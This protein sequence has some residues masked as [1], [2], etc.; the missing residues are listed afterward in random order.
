LALILCFTVGCQDKAAMAELEAFKAQAEVEEQNKAL[1]IRYSEAWSK[2]D[3]EALKE[4]FSPDFVWH[5][6]GAHLSL[7]ETIESLKQQIAM[8][9][10][11]TI[12]AQDIIVKE[13][14]LISRYIFRGTHEGDT[15]G[16]PA[17]GKT[18]EINGIEI[19]RIEDRKIVESWEVPD[20][21]SFALQIGM[22]LKPKEGEK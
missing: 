3:I 10:D 7:E 15:E 9:T 21:L 20:S 11:R 16:L 2:G 1:A 17:T 12:L 14:K 13:D 4:I 5:V 19:I 18:I 22:E 8:L 6:S